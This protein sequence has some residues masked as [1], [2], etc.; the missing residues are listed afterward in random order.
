MSQWLQAVFQGT[1]ALIISPAAMTSFFT[2]GKLHSLPVLQCCESLQ[3]TLC[4]K[5]YD[6]FKQQ[7]CWN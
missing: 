5:L 4:S 3:A 2:A 7:L 1:G 6:S